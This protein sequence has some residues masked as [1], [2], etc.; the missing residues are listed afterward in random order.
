M[1]ARERENQMQTEIN[2]DQE[3]DLETERQKRL[4]TLDRF[5]AC[6]IRKSLFSRLNKKAK[7]AMR[8]WVV[9]EDNLKITGRAFAVHCGV[10]SGSNRE[11]ENLMREALGT[12][13]DVNQAVN[14][15]INIMDELGSALAPIRRRGRV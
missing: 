7:T 1:K 14:D 15:A 4:A 12:K 8:E 10:M 9:R 2:H 11:F 3:L 13:K 5:E 6:S